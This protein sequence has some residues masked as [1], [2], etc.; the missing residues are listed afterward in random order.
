MAHN[1]IYVTYYRQILIQHKFK[2]PLTAK[3]TLEGYSTPSQWQ[4]FTEVNVAKAEKERDNSRD[5]RGVVE[6]I[7]RRTTGK[8]L[9]LNICTFE[10]LRKHDRGKPKMLFPVLRTRQGDKNREEEDDK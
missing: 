7:L 1:V 2:R 8:I 3:V 5:L 4:N 9:N 6:G 10:N